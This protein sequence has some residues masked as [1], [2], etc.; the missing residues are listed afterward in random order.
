MSKKPKA[1]PGFYQKVAY[2]ETPGRHGFPPDFTPFI[3]SFSPIAPGEVISPLGGK[4][5]YVVAQDRSLR[6]LDA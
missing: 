3:A 4:H 1:E 2:L 5:T 6:R